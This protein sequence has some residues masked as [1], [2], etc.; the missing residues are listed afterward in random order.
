MLIKQGLHVF[1]VQ[2]VFMFSVNSLVLTVITPNMVNVYSIHCNA[3]TGKPKLLHSN[4]I[5]IFRRA[6]V[7]N[8]PSAIMHLCYI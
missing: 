1:N 8:E 4:M 7:L 3:Q 5:M 2:Y 6:E